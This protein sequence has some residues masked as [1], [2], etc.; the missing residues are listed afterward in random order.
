MNIGKSAGVLA[1]AGLSL[2]CLPARGQDVTGVQTGETA[3]QEGEQPAAPPGQTAGGPHLT[4]GGGLSYQSEADIHNTGE[5]F[6]LT[7]FDLLLGVPIPLNDALELTTMF[8]YGLDS[9]AFHDGPDPWHNIHTFSGTAILHYQ[10]DPRFS[11]YGGALLRVSA[12][13]GADFDEAFSGG[14]L[15]GVNYKFTDNFSAG[16]GLAIVSQIEDDP[17]VLP[18]ITIDWRFADAWRAKVGFLDVATMGYGGM[19]EFQPMDQWLFDFGIQFHKARF[20]IETADDV[21]QEEA[22]ILFAQATFRP[23]SIV[24][25]SGFVG[26]AVGGNLRLEDSSGDRITDH[27]YDAA[28]VIG[29]KAKFRL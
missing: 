26:V 3:Q 15:A 25:L 13:S 11:I 28:A 23:S 22:A 17:L 16:L 29:L 7:R 18:L 20:R 4:I 10:L 1:L 2:M 21:G 12:E 19:V 5:N 6:S 9:Y 24:D 8:R 14:G 27:D